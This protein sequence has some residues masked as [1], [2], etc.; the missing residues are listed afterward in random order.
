L[1]ARQAHGY[2]AQTMSDLG[3]A[4]L[5][6]SGALLVAWLLAAG[7]A[8]KLRRRDRGSPWT[9]ERVGLAALA[10]VAI[11]FGVQSLIDW[12]WFVPGPAVMAIAAAGLV[13]GSARVL[14]DPAP[15]ADAAGADPDRPRLRWPRFAAA[16]V[17]LVAICA[18]AW[19]AWQPQR[20]H[21]QAQRAF[22][23]LAQNRPGAAQKAADD[24]RRI[25]PLALE[26][27]FARAAVLEQRGDLRGAEAQLALGVREH[28][29]DPAA[30]LRLA[31]FQLFSLDEPKR[32]QQTLLGVLSLDPNS[33]EGAYA[34]FET[35][36]RLRGGQPA[37]GAPPVTPPAGP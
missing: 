29:S 1:V 27:L 22:D 35:R 13:A 4:G 34:Y 23:L 21:I 10:C 24:A 25:N 19:A 28:R 20:S 37:A 30:W 2:V 18:C 8:L 26:P 7:R 17:A 36:V 12:T 32:A 3:L 15:D 11:V 9:P 33:R 14:R 6:V 16:A 5:V 31:Q